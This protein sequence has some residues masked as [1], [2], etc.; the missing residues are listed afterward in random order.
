MPWGVVIAFAA[1]MAITTGCRQSLGL[2]VRP[3]A[4]T[5][6]GIA[7][8]SFALAAGQFFWG[9]CQ[10]AFG[11]LADR[12]GS[13]RVIVLGGVLMAAGF[14]LVPWL[15]SVSGLFLT[16]GVLS[17]IGGGA[18]SFA[19]V[20]GAVAR[21]VPGA[22]Q[23][24]ASAYV[25]A[26]ASLGQFIIAPAAQLVMGIAGWPAAM[27]MLAA[28][29]TSTIAIAR[30]AARPAITETAAAPL[31][32][33]PIRDLMRP[34]FRD[35]SY[36]CLH[37][38]FFACGFHVAFLV[39]HLP[40]EIVV[41]GLPASAAGV[42]I[43]LIGLANVV[44]TLG[45]GWLA[46]RLRLKSLL[47]ALYFARVLAI[48]CYLLAPKTLFTLYVFSGALGLAW[49][50]TVPLTAGLVAKLF[51]PRHLATLFGLTVMSHQ[52]GGFF[53]AWL[54]GVAVARTGNYH[55]M[56]L[57]DMILATMAALVHLPVRELPL[58]PRAAVS[59]PAI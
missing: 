56:W 32:R 55:W 59:T 47:V 17:A 24:M 34:A 51:G 50:P 3:L 6:V 9:A 15:T 13:Y 53:G 54:G 7:A 43:G 35:R 21:R 23:T 37:I 41:C 1:L 27:W 38:G 39:T 29:A 28:A 49:L 11:I 48:G 8:V 20:I 25:N 26:G 57:L 14:A 36:R 2:F 22:H 5:G 42:A 46:L 33:V 18:G 31:A 12:I 52:V 10:P 30:P 19:I 16:L 45:F 44:G 58:A 4:A 40:G